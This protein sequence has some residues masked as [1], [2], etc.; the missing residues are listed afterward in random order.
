M[1]GSAIESP[2]P[3]ADRW[4]ARGPGHPLLPWRP[5]L[6]DLAL[7]TSRNTGRVLVLSDSGGAVL[8]VD[9]ERALVEQALAL[10]LAP[11][12]RWAGW[13]DG[14]SIDGGAST[15]E[16]GWGYWAS[17]VFDPS[18]EDLLGVLAVC[19]PTCTRDTP[20]L[21]T[22]VAR[23]AEE[24]VR[25]DRLHP[26]L[27]DQIGVVANQGGVRLRVLGPG[28]PVAEVAGATIALTPRR[29]DI[30]F[31]LTRHADGLSADALAQELY[32]DSGNPLTVRVEVHRIRTLLG[33]RLASAPYRFGVPVTTDADVVLRLVACGRIEEAVRRYTGP[34]LPRSESLGIEQLRAELH[35]TVRA[36]ALSAGGDVLAV[37]CDRDVGEGDA[38]ALDGYLATLSPLDPVRLFVQTRLAQLELESPAPCN[39]RATSAVGQWPHG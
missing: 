27:D 38:E 18:T 5:L 2:R 1:S 33:A 37:W 32:G 28:L 16:S 15:T 23:L 34:L 6:R 29:A 9:G 22:A 39:P 35:Q 10:G 14:R 26:P 7:G 3:K 21:V 30:L 25:R 8:W 24:L 4:V 20:L 17:P 36:A 13:A 31:L 12:F 11:G 19:G